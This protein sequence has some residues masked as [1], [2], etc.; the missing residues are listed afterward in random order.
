[1]AFIS[2]VRTSDNLSNIAIRMVHKKSKRKKNNCESGLGNNSAARIRDRYHEN[3]IQL[4]NVDWIIYRSRILFPIYWSVG[5]IAADEFAQVNRE[6]D[7]RRN[8]VHRYTPNAY[9]YNFFSSSEC[10]R[11]YCVGSSVWDRTANERKSNL[12]FMR[13]WKG[14]FSDT[15]LSS[16]FVFCVRKISHRIHSFPPNK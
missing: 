2:V 4:L 12:F 16:S 15:F 10:G 11:C 13:Q 7:G 8:D 14:G 3:T 5:S 1:M 6:S 9:I